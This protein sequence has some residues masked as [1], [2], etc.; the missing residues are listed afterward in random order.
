MVDTDLKDRL[1]TCSIGDEELEKSAKSLLQLM[2]NEKGIIV[3]IT[4]GRTACKR[5]NEMGLVPG[6]EI[7]LVN[8]INSGP[9]M[10]KVKGS[11]LALG[12]GLACKVM[13]I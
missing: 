4:G 12:R 2:V 11:K 8:K 7:E 9:V 3:L 10:I 6:T 5:L 13:V 1:Y